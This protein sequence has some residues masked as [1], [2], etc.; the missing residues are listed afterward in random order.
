MTRRAFA[1]VAAVLFFFAAA[2]VRS[3]GDERVYPVYLLS[4]PPAADMPAEDDPAW[5]D[6]PESAGFTNILSRRP[7]PRETRFRAAY[8]FEALHLAFECRPGGD[9]APDDGGS[10]WRADH[11]EI[12]FHPPGGKH[13]TQFALNRRGTK[14]AA[15]WTARFAG[16]TDIPDNSW[17]VSASDG[18]ESWTASV[19]IPFETLGIL[20]EDDDSW[21]FNVIR[22]RPGD[23]PDSWSPRLETDHHELQSFGRLHFTGTI[24]PAIRDTF[25]DRDD[26]PVF[27]FAR[28]GSGIYLREGLREDRIS[29]AQADYSAPALAPGG[30]TILYHS[31]LGGEGR[32]GIMAAGK[33]GSGYSVRLCEG[34]F[35]RW[36]PDGTLIAFERNGEIIA[37][38]PESGAEETLVADPVLECLFPSWNSAGILT[39][40]ARRKNG[41]RWGIYR[42]GE[43]GDRQ[44]LLETAGRPASRPTL[45]PDGRTLAFEEGHRVMLYNLETG[46]RRPL[47]PGP[48][49][50]G[51]PAW[52]RD[53]RHLAYLQS[54][55][56][57]RGPYDLRLAEAR[58]NG[59]SALIEREVHPAFDWNGILPEEPPWD[60]PHGVRIA[61]AVTDARAELENGF[62]KLTVCRRHNDILLASGT[63]ETGLYFRGRS[64]TILET[65]SGFS[66]GGDPSVGMTVRVRL[67][68]RGE[69]EEEFRLF[70]P[71]DAPFL[72]VDSPGE[73]ATLLL[74]GIFTRAVLPDRLLPDLPVTPGRS[75]DDPV[76]PRAPAMLAFRPGGGL[77][78][79]L[80]PER[81]Q[82]L[83]MLTAGSNFS[84]VEIRTAG[85]PVFIAPLE[86]PGLFHHQEPA[87]AA[88]N[89]LPADWTPPFPALWRAT[90]HTGD[91]A[92][93]TFLDTAGP[94]EKP[95]LIPAGDFAAGE[96]AAAFIY[97]YGRNRHTA[98]SLFTPADV[99]TAALGPERA[100]ELLGA[101]DA[102]DYR[103]SGR[104]VPARL[105]RQFGK[106]GITG[107]T[108]VF[109][110]ARL[111]G[112]EEGFQL[113]LNLHDD[114]V[115]IIEGLDR[116]AAEYEDFAA[117][118]PCGGA[119]FEP[120]R[121]LPAAEIALSGE[122]RDRLRRGRDI[123]NRD[124]TYLAFLE[125]SAAA[126]EARTALLACY[127]RHF[128]SRAHAA[129]LRALAGDRREPDP[130]TA[131]N[132]CREILGRRYY[133]E[134]DWRG[135]TP[136]V[137]I[138]LNARDDN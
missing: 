91:H 23:S 30:G 22:N 113:A 122:E 61:Q 110:G 35:A 32:P 130:E 94:G 41:D 121:V 138:R 78:M 86:G 5:A 12:F 120:P 20:P 77:L 3:G 33:S 114:I 93:S 107:R 39:F 119:R 63:G 29:Y 56:K 83:K 62:L 74:A 44:R 42:L 60:P 123:L 111:A 68:A 6:I 67:R 117:A 98:L 137:E 108:M 34:G 72:E 126:F 69:P 31:L 18:T 65:I 49:A 71:A 133:F 125:R 102:R 8:T 75:G 100:G 116:R 48:G 97:L 99:I 59:R 73:G 132:A 40:A 11:L 28:P 26:R 135:E 64:G 118:M 54:P 92:E 17:S 53:G 106:R 24:P 70:L 128:R 129:G 43:A 1:A 101:P 109:G 124:S 87:P 10:V 104:R 16:Q 27:L 112:L 13:Y 127:R 96:E 38:C 66:T 88:E 89:G 15:S 55:E 80:A 2:P 134:G 52:S 14:W 57:G 115:A 79:V 4:R 136:G 131:R 36:H 25:A 7:S 85:E 90:L 84:G 47:A 19:T 9:G 95:T 37:R 82:S 46:K 105:Y 21:G 81:A 103:V 50:Q 51:W 58:E 45:S 76:L